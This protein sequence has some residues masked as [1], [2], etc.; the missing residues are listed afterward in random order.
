MIN[1]VMLVLNV[2]QRDSVIHIHVSV[3]FQIPFPLK[4]L[5]N[6]DQSSLYHPVGLCWLSS[7]NKAVYMSMPDSLRTSLLI[8]AQQ[9]RKFD[10]GAAV[11]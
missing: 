7:L 9:W 10:S 5:H 3:L 6:I 4:L 11:L 8:N 1:N 2:Q